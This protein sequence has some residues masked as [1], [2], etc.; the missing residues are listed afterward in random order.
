M[1]ETI[2]KICFKTDW[3]GGMLVQQV[4]LPRDAHILDGVIIAPLS[5]IHL[6]TNTLVKAADN[7][8]IFGSLHLLGK[9][10]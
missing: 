2:S 8:Q 9:H 7:A 4:K 1:D 10:R 3:M 5:L 6:S